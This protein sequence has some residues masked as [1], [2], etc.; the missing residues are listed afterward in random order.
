MNVNYNLV[1]ACLKAGQLITE[2]CLCRFVHLN[3][4]PMLLLE[5]QVMKTCRCFSPKVLTIREICSLF[6]RYTAL[7]FPMFNCSLI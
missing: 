4:V 6:R 1:T 7:E 3:I 2:S 5:L